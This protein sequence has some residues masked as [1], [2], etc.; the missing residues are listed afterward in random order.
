MLDNSRIRGDDLA[1][2]EGDD[3]EGG[4]LACEASYVVMDPREVEEEMNDGAHSWVV[5]LLLP[6]S[7]KW[8]FVGRYEFNGYEEEE[9]KEKG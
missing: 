6:F 7:V 8:E 5:L 9:E 3:P 4:V 2:E 1:P